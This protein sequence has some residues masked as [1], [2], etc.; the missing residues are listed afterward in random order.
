MAKRQFLLQ[1]CVGE[2][3]AMSGALILGRKLKVPRSNLAVLAKDFLRRSREW[4]RLH[5]PHGNNCAQVCLW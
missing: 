1:D 5:Q 4:R 3:E 2:L